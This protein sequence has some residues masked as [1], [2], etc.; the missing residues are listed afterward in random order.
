MRTSHLQFLIDKGQE[1]NSDIIR[2]KCAFWHMCTLTGQCCVV[3]RCAFLLWRCLGWTITYC[4]CFCVKKKYQQ[5]C[6]VEEGKTRPHCL[7]LRWLFS[8]ISTPLDNKY[9]LHL[10][11]TVSAPQNKAYGWEELCH[12]HSN[13]TWG[14]NAYIIVGVAILICVLATLLSLMNLFW[15]LTQMKS[16]C[17]NISA[18]TTDPT[19]VTDIHRDRKKPVQP[20]QPL[21][22]WLLH[23]MRVAALKE[24]ER[25]F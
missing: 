6:L 25:D 3:H 22:L 8:L 23:G 17:I 1:V 12:S 14:K 10:K 21:C 20:F 24:K 18:L 9:I 15:I 7:H 11:L 5:T 4:D 19:Q 13:I 2:V 16:P